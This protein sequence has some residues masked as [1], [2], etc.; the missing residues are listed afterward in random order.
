VYCRSLLEFVIH[1]NFITFYLIGNISP[2][3]IF[4][5]QVLHL[6][7]S[8]SIFDFDFKCEVRVFKSE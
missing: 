2:S 6:G 4:H 8:A 1:Y 7:Q 3:V 5:G